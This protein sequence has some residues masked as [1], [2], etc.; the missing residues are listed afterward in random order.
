M[1]NFFSWA[2][3]AGLEKNIPTP[4]SLFFTFLLGPL[5]LTFHLITRYAL[6]LLNPEREPLT[7][8]NEQSHRLR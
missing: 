1:T 8:C 6:N 4:H 2:R 7:R 3:L 5:G